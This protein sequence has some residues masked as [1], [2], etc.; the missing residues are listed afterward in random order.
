MELLYVP[1]ITVTHFSEHWGKIK[2]S[3]K[4]LK[5]VQRFSERGLGGHHRQ[6]ALGKLG[7]RDKKG[8]Q[9]AAEEQLQ[10]AS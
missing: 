8:I 6:K 4:E 3:G 5:R 7:E 10:K 1:K 9:A 2:V